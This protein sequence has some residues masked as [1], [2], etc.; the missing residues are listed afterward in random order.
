M[1]YWPFI[2][3]QTVISWEENSYQMQHIQYMARLPKMLRELR[4]FPISVP[5]ITILGS[6]RSN[7]KIT[8]RAATIF[9]QISNWLL[10]TKERLFII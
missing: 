9:D 3:R 2:Q 1:Q 5:C 4:Q 8:A 7:A 10:K 6:S